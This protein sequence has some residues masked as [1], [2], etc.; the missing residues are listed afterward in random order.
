MW[1]LFQVGGGIWPEVVLVSKD[2][3]A[4]NFYDGFGGAGGGVSG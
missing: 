1:A 3:R 2:R 4:C